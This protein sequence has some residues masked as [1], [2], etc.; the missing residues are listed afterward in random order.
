M[1]VINLWSVR[2]DKWLQALDYDM[3]KWEDAGSCRES[4][5]FR[6]LRGTLG[7]HLR[8]TKLHMKSSLNPKRHNIRKCHKKSLNM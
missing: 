2:L 4:L 7:W 3:K 6:G 5:E 8:R 1:H